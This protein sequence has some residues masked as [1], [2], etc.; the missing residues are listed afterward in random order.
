MLKAGTCSSPDRQA[1]RQS[2]YRN[3]EF[4]WQRFWLEMQ[5][6]GPEQIGIRALSTHESLKLAPTLVVD[7]L[8]LPTFRAS[9]FGAG[10]S[11]AA[12]K[13]PARITLAPLQP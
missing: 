2:S 13:T 3:T 4:S 1:M 7:L 6:S 11:T 9:P 12:K 10:G 8:A 5:Y